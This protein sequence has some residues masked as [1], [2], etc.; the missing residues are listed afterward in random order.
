MLFHPHNHALIPNI[1]H[2]NTPWML[3]DGQVLYTRWEYVDR[4]RTRYHHLWT[5]NPDGTAQ[6][7]FF[8]NMHPSTVMID[9]KPIPHTDKV[10]SIF[11]PGHGRK[12]HAGAMT[13]V[14]PD[15]GPDDLKSAR[16]KT[17]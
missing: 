12:E 10:V 9:A 14:D 1:E 7:V 6:M 16:M 15:A 4:S 5:A 2:D 13:V 11:S 3:P 17:A 8:G